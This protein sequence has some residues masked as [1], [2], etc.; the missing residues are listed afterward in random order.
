[1]AEIGRAHGDRHVYQPIRIV[2]FGIATDIHGEAGDA[3][4]VE[5]YATR[6]PMA[7]AGQPDE[8]AAAVLWMLSDEASY[9]TAAVLPVGGGR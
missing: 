7:R 1:M 4:R 6:M 5:R 2:K 8:I 9:V 3:D